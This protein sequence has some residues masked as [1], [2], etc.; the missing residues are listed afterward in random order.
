MAGRSV[1]E[2]GA[3]GGAVAPADDVAEVGL[4]L[5]GV[6]VLLGVAGG[7]DAGGRVAPDR[8]RLLQPLAGNVGRSGAVADLALDVPK[9]VR[10]AQAGAADLAVTGDVAAD[11]LEVV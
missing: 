7:A 1:A 10:V 9:A 5:E 8:E 3:R 6:R 11:A 4:V 2:L